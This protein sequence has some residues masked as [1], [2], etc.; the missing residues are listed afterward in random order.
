MSSENEELVEWRDSKSELTVI[1]DDDVAYASQLLG[2][3]VKRE[4]RVELFLS[5]KDCRYCPLAKSLLE[6]LASFNP[7]IKLELRDLDL[8]K[9]RAREYAL[10][11]APSTVI[12]ANNGTKFYYLGVPSGNQLRSLAEDIT[13]AS[14]GET[15]MSGFARRS[16]SSVKRPM[17]VDVFVTPTCPYSPIVVRAAHRLAMENANL[18]S[19]MIEII[20]F[21]DMALKYNVMGV[22]KILIDDKIVF[23]GALAEEALAEV[24]EAAS[25]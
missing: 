23:D 12:H 1:K 22:P 18:R 3:E 8:D 17:S 11:Q 13:D 24:L 21:P 6:Q 16:V 25:R 4:V 7:L 19:R 14:R 10:E 20:E 5:E 9:E 15:N 2:S